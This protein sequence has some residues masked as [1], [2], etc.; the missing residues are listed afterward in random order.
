MTTYQIANDIPNGTM[1]LTAL[2]D[3]SP[4][5][6]IDRELTDWSDP[7]SAIPALATITNHALG[8]CSK[9]VEAISNG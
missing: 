5:C 9:C 6:G 1:H 3:S 8:A 7:I 4:M 2:G